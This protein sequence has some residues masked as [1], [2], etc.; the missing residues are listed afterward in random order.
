MAV[1]YMMRLSPD[2]AT[3]GLH[4]NRL[5]PSLY[6]DEVTFTNFYRYHFFEIKR[7]RPW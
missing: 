4:I 2:I 7:R 1:R 6:V 5:P 3:R